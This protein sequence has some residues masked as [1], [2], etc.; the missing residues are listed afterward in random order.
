MRYI[1]IVITFLSVACKTSQK[2]QAIQSA[3]EKKD[4][5]QTVL[6]KE[7]PKVD[8]EA[9][10][11]HILGKVMNKKV[12]FV[13]FNTRINVDYESAEQSQKF[14]A[15][16]GMKKDSI[17]FIKIVGK[18]L[19][20]SKVA[21]QIKIRPDSVFLVNEIDRW[22][23]KTSIDYLQDTTN[24][25]FDFKTIQDILVGNPVFLDSNIVSYRAGNS[26]LQVL[27]IGDIFK[28]LITLD[29]N[30]FRVLHSKLDDVDMMRSRTC[31]ISFGSYDVVD[32]RSFAK[33]RLISVSEKSKLDI[34]LDFK[35]SSFND[36]LKYSFNVPK[37]YKRK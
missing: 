30:D 13:T 34:Y 20:I 21:M 28:H 10:V 2:V 31:D 7:V 16:L 24:I 22:V 1:F 6:V 33:Y 11:K 37:N 17:I 25:P 4:T 14:V 36:P 9:I 29:N 35:E 15:Y 32:G 27:M 3:I 19:G 8:S 23:K 12:D 5:A 18:F 26:Q